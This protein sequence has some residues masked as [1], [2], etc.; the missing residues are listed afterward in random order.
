MSK[1]NQTNNNLRLGLL[2]LLYVSNAMAMDTQAVREFR[3]ANGLQ[4][5]IK[6]DNRAEVVVTQIWYRVGSSYEH[7]G[8]T[9]ISHALEHMMFK[10]TE[11]YPD[12]QFSQIISAQGGSNNAFTSKDYT[13]YFQ[14]LQKDSLEISLSLEADRMKNLLLPPDE[15]TKE[16]AVVKE[17]R[18]LRTEDNP[19]AYTYEVA[20]ATAFQTSGY[21][22]PIIGWMQ[23]LNRLQ[24]RQMR[25]WYKD[26]YHPN[27]AI[28]IVVGDVVPAEVFQLA[29]KHFGAIPPGKAAQAPQNREIQQQGTKRIKVKRQAELPHLIMSY[30]VP[31]LKALQDSYYSNIEAWEP[32][33]I[34]VLTHILSGGESARLPG[35]LVRNQ[36]IA[37]VA[38]SYY[39]LA[40][41]LPTSTF[42]LVGTPAQEHSTKSLEFAFRQQINALQTKPVEESE[43][44]R[45][46][47]Q[48][49]AS[50]IYEKDSMFYQGMIMGILE[51]T[52]LGWEI[53]DQ[54]VENMN[55]VTAKQI[56]AVAKKYLVD[57]NLTVTEL[58]PLDKK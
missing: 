52:G 38:S 12:D 32:Y 33:A 14:T 1:F 5:L 21:R 45:V 58:I 34:E 36:E 13:A 55:R 22:H 11:N 31:S 35:D 27:N 39:Q 26:W 48:A 10:G 7:E 44:Q 9:G 17:E 19:Q 47:A 50:N 54:Y 51:T 2:L 37:A 6:P 49:I 24:L 8:I 42:N 43:L 16:I 25:Q 18:R 53:A 56:M 40:R 23:D 57:D 41:R 46:K 20:M 15:F 28:L 4:L 3:L 30:K 29:E